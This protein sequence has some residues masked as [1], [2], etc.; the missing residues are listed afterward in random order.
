MKRNCIVLS[1]FSFI[2]S[3]SDAQT[4]DTLNFIN[5]FS[6]F[7]S[8]I[9]T[10]ST[11][12]IASVFKNSKYFDH[13]V[14]RRGYPE[15][16]MNDEYYQ[17]YRIVEVDFVTFCSIHP[18][19][20]YVS[21]FAF[22]SPI[23]DSTFISDKLTDDGWEKDAWYSDTDK[24]WRYLYRKKINEINY[25]LNNQNFPD[26]LTIRYHVDIHDEKYGLEH[27]YRKA[28]KEHKL[29]EQVE[30]IEDSIASLCSIDLVKGVFY[31]KSDYEV[32]ENYSGAWEYRNGSMLFQKGFYKSGKRDGKWVVYNRSGKVETIRMY[33][34]GVLDGEC[35]TFYE[36]GKLWE[37]SFYKN[38]QL[39]GWRIIYWPNG[40]IK[41]RAHYRKNKQVGKYTSYWDNG[42]L[43][44]IMKIKRGQANGLEVWYSKN[45]KEIKRGRNKNGL[46]EG[47]WV[48]HFENGTIL[49][50]V[51]Y[52][53][54]KVYYPEAIFRDY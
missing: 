25:T 23:T 3:L 44:I 49:S 31:A 33:K 46:K 50:K 5:H 40:S 11:C 16:A 22:Y 12:R 42:Q 54:G 9:D 27:K 34:N 53:R 13:N 20:D 41:S 32:P 38:M 39:H 21:M 47:K 14:N 10:S 36:D 4:L 24:Y 17:K 1:L 29:K 48:E 37:K 28:A 35:L 43:S 26:Q 8:L 52:R 7:I 45:G 2:I 18:D 51:I 30:H 15:Y 19:E 6:Q